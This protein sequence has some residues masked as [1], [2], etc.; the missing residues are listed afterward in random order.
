MPSF[1][2]KEII[3]IT[4]TMDALI[5]ELH[6]LCEEGEFEKAEKVSTEIKT[7]TELLPTY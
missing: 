2:T 3:D 4:N 5:D 7:I 1:D 6:A